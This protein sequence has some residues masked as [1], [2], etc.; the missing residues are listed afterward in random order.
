MVCE[1]NPWALGGSPMFQALDTE[2][3]VY[4]NRLLFRCGSPLLLHRAILQYQLSDL[5][6]D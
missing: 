2:E 6:Q 4:E 5:Q 3:G 1:H